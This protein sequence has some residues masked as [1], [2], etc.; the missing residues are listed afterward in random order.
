MWIREM[1]EGKI[2]Y[3]KIVYVS[4]NE[5][6]TDVS[7]KSMNYPKYSKIKQNTKKKY[8]TDVMLMQ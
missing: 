4:W 8:I 5:W 1:Y 3:V 2:F 6:V 7:N